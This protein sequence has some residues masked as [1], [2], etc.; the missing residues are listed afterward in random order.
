MGAETRLGEEE[1]EGILNL[2]AGEEVETNRVG[3]QMIAA[4]EAVVVAPVQL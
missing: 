3:R 1:G 4:G 2:E